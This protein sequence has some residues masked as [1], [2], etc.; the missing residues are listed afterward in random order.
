MLRVAPALAAC[1]ADGRKLH[2]PNTHELRVAPA[3]VARRA[4]G[5]KP[6]RPSCSLWNNA[7]I[8]KPTPV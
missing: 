1:R 8:S 2:R 4:D 3:Q 6:N 5:R 7:P